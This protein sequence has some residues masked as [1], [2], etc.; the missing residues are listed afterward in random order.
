MWWCPVGIQGRVLPLICPKKKEE[1]TRFQRTF[2]R[3]LLAVTQVSS[4]FSSN[5]ASVKREQ[6]KFIDV[7]INFKKICLSPNLDSCLHI[8]MEE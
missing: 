7:A 6:L 8:H 3:S 4:D 1:K 5:I 2:I